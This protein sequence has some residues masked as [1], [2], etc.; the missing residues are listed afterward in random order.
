[1][2]RDLIRHAER[3]AAVTRHQ[4]AIAPDAP[5]A[6]IAFSWTRCLDQY[7]IDPARRHQTLVL[8]AA[9]LRERRQ[10]LS[11]FM[12]LARLQMDNLHQQIAGSGF[13][14][15]LTDAEGVILDNVTD[16]LRQREFSRAGLWHGAVWDERLEGTNGI[17]TCLFEKRPVTVHQDEHFR[18]NHIGLTCSGAPIFDPAGGLMAVLDASSASSRDSKQSQFHTAALVTLSAKLIENCSFLQHY[19]DAWVLRFHSRP[20]F[21]GLISEGMLAFDGDGR[22]RAVNQGALNQLRQQTREALLGRPVAELFDLDRDSL[23]LRSSRR[24]SAVWPL[25]DRTGQG[26]FAML[27]GPETHRLQAVR[28]VCRS[29]RVR[30]GGE[31]LS[32]SLAQCQGGDARMA[33][34]VRCARRVV[35]RDI[36][37]ILSGETG[38]GKELFARAVHAA[39]ARADRPFLAL[40][41]AAIPEQLIESELF[42]YKDGAFTGARR[43]GMRGKL[44]QAHGGTL[45][46]DEIG[47]MPLH[48]QTRL[49][50][51]LEEREVTPLGSDKAI[52]LDVQIISASHADLPDLVAR[53]AFREDLYYRLNGITLRL[54]AL[55]E[56]TDFEALVHAVLREEN[57]DCPVALDADALERLRAFRWPGNIR[58]LRNALRTALALGDGQRIGVDDLPPEIAVLGGNRAGGPAPEA[59]AA[60]ALAAAER[61]ALLQALERHDW[62]VTRTAAQLSMSRN[63]LYRK[64]RRH[65]IRPG[66]GQRWTETTRQG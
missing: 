10:R 19:R 59:E 42:G 46:L 50:R 51:V 23:L 55:R 26:Y 48:L 52:P 53:G 25:R 24:P 28:P 18:G 4:P 12:D 35:D 40:N 14:I 33:Y 58:Q 49:L 65:G 9:E 17:G 54:P 13:A 27:V 8:D 29:R 3:I 41:C 64:L 5:E 60:D 43:G 62:N 44:E 20:E 6:S 11:G 32:L 31:P 22:I 56:R 57:G 34:N 2:A 16:P 30:P 66:A 45:F 21:I 36:S 47:D 63:T 61:R 39:S 1:M 38:T 7:G 37:L 15:I